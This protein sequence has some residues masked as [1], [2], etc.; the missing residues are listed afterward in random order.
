V[1][2][3]MESHRVA[4]VA[5]EAGVAALAVRAV[6]D[7][8]DWALPMLATRALGADGRPKIGAVAAGL[9]RRPG[10]LG[11]LLRVKRDTEAA[12][13]TLSAVADGSITAML[14]AR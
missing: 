4:R 7:P 9:L 2:V 13:A 5:A 12:L 8:A 14:A 10:D 11:L 1:A 6:G 3:D